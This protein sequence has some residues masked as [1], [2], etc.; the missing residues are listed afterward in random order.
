M[1][2]PTKGS[3]VT[4]IDARTIPATGGIFLR[5]VMVSG[6]KGRHCNSGHGRYLQVLTLK[7][8]QNTL[9]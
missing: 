5:V 8:L 7:I 6:K 3:V 2:E 9:V 4:C 1:A